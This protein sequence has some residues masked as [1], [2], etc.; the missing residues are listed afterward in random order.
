MEYTG[1]TPAVYRPVY[2]PYGIPPVLHD[3]GRIPAWLD[4][5]GSVP[6]YASAPLD[7]SETLGHPPA[8]SL[9]AG[10]YRQPPDRP[11]N[12][13]IRLVVNPHKVT[14]LWRG[15]PLMY[16][17]PAPGKEFTPTTTR[18]DTPTIYDLA[19]KLQRLHQED[20]G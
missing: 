12:D 10:G 4:P 2:P 13:D 11:M 19:R 16:A 15:V 8:D 6:K 1:T 17:H 7:T 14:L 5:P 20:I 18:L 3:S 9:L